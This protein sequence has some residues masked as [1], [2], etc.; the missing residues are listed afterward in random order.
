MMCIER[1][2]PKCLKINDQDG[3]RPPFDTALACCGIYGGDSVEA[4][5]D[6]HRIALG[7]KTSAGKIEFSCKAGQK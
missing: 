3:I 2:Q 1:Y 6:V 5:E 7:L 4:A